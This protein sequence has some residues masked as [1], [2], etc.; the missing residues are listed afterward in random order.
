MQPRYAELDQLLAL[1]RRILDPQL[2]RGIVVVLDFRQLLVP[3]AAGIFEQQ[4]EVK[5]RTCGA[6]RIGKIPGTIGT[7]TPSLRR[8]STEAIKIIVVEKQLG[9]DRCRAGVDFFFEKSQIRFAADGARMDF[10]KTRHRHAKSTPSPARFANQLDGM[11]KTV[12]DGVANP[13]FPGAD[14]R[15]ARERF[16]SPFL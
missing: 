14:R 15:R 1:A 16:Q 11:V 5:R 10:R 9:D 7:V 8:S 3:V 13:S 12:R 2:N 4:S 6:E